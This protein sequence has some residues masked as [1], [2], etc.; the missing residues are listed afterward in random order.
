MKFPGF[1]DQQPSAL[2][3]P[4]MQE[5][6]AGGYDGLVE[7]LTSEAGRQRVRGAWGAIDAAVGTD[8]RRV[9][10]GIREDGAGYFEVYGTHDPEVF[11]VAM[12]DLRT[13]GSEPVWVT[14]VHRGTTRNGDTTVAFTDPTRPGTNQSAE[15]LLRYAPHFGTSSYLENG[16]HGY[17]QR[18][19]GGAE[20]LPVAVTQLFAGLDVRQLRTSELDT[21]SV[22]RRLRINHPVP[23]APSPDWDDI[24][25]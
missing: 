19:Q 3:S 16:Y 2:L 6:A 14:G 22:G 25:I 24:G 9:F 15:L 12:V 18:G 4:A 7:T 21:G 13:D 20:L 11:G 1:R 8:S 17:A 10:A 5:L 23:P